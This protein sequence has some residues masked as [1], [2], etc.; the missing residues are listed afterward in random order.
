MTR[1]LH[2]SGLSERVLV[3][4]GRVPTAIEPHL[5]TVI[6]RNFGA[7]IFL[8][9]A[10]SIA[11]APAAGVLLFDGTLA[12]AAFI[13]VVVA[14][15]G[16]LGYCEM[17]RSLR[18]INARVLAVDEGEYDVDF[19]VSRVDEI[20]ETYDA[21]ERM[22]GSLDERIREARSARETAEA[23]REE[24]E[25]ERQEMAALTGHLEL[26]AQE[27]ADALAA[28]ADGDLTVRVDTDSMNEAMGTV[29]EQINAT[30][31]DLERAIDRSQSAADRI[32]TE[33]DAAAR[34]GEEIRAETEAAS[35]ATAGIA[36]RADVQRE[37]LDDAAAE[38]SDL[39]ATVEEMASSVTEVAEQSE[40]AAD[41]GSE[42][43]ESSSEAQSAIDAIRRQTGSAV[44]EIEELDEIAGQVA[45]V[46]ELI[47]DIAEETNVLA[48]NAAI[49]AARAGEEGAG[50]AVVADEV[51]GLAEETQEATGEVE[52]LIES[53]QSQVGDSR[54]EIE[55]MQSEVDRGVGTISETIT[56]LNEIV[57]ATVATNGAIQELDRA[58]DQQADSAQEVVTIIDDVTEIAERTAREADEVAETTR[59]QRTVVES[60]SGSV[61]AFADEATDLRASLSDFEAAA[62]V[63][64]D[65]HTD[66]A[67]DGTAP[68]DVRADT[69][70][71]DVDV[72]PD[73]HGNSVDGRAEAHEGGVDTGIGADADDAETGGEGGEE[74]TS[75]ARTGASGDEG[76]AGAD[77]GEGTNAGTGTADDGRERDRIT[78]SATGDDN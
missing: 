14:A 22:A 77:G 11:F 52:A 78:G 62:G 30:L 49:E 41:L 57:D 21:F 69:H 32:A 54:E 36:E 59:E 56:T 65:D 15:T 4:V 23:A 27:Y 17:Y 53:M 64:V 46:V 24:A 9:A 71:D 16:F 8:L 6:R 45:E 28:A 2:T 42:A 19:G 29:G 33:S 13:S 35:E 26:K 7:R 39:S 34:R 1:K 37:R 51:K 25:E 75:D 5:P 74:T 63:G 48:L 43:Q 38:M 18:E 55:S 72:D 12:V 76:A 58:A 10:T 20:G 68:V 66:G 31:A 47:D 40:T 44:E 67:T 50:F 3:T 73:A 61:E 60:V 70:E